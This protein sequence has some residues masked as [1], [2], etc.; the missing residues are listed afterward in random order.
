MDSLQCLRHIKRLR[1][2]KYAKKLAINCK[3]SVL[4]PASLTIKRLAR[5]FIKA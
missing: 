5:G 1:V 4:V 2:T 3:N